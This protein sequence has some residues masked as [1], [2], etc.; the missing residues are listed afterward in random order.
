MKPEN[1]LTAKQ[2]RESVLEYSAESIFENIISKSRLGVRELCLPA[3]S[4]SDSVRAM[5]IDADYELR[6]GGS[7]NEVLVIKW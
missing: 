6:I 4:V 2:A 7:D 3:V 1:Y 5:L